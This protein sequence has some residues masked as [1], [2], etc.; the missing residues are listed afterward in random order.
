MSEE[1]AW[2]AGLFVGEGSAGNYKYTNKAG[3]YPPRLQLQMQD[4]VSVEHFVGIVSSIEGVGDRPMNYG[5]PTHG[6]T[7][8]CGYASLQ[9]KRAILALEALL[10]YLTGRKAEQ[11]VASLARGGVPSPR[12]P[13]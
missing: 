11:V 1:L 9:G 13:R 4:L 2:A 7:K 6:R 3:H 12:R 5:T 8:R 10:P